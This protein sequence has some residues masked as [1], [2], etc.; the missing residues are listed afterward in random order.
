MTHSYPVALATPVLVR[1]RDKMNRSL[2]FVVFEGSIS[3]RVMSWFC[4]LK[5][6]LWTKPKQNEYIPQSIKYA[7]LEALC[8]LL[9]VLLF[10][11]F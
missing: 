6:P 4:V 8:F 3:G 7:E 1:N 9:L 11:D 5:W 2:L 10:S